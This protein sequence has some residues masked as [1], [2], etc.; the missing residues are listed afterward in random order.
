MHRTVLAS[1]QGHA[2]KHYKQKTKQTHSAGSV[3]MDYAE[4]LGNSDV[5]VHTQAKVDKRASGGDASLPAAHHLVKLRVNG[6][7]GIT[8]EPGAD[9]GVIWR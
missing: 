8:V 5:Q 6:S 7:L 3:D 2:F 4:S 1:K 9:N